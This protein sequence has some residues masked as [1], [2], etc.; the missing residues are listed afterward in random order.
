MKYIWTFFFILFMAATGYFIYRLGVWD[1]QIKPRLWNF[2]EL[3]R[4]LKSTLEDSIQQAA[5]EIYP[6]DT[7][8]QLIQSLNS[9]QKLQEN[10]MQQEMEKVNQMKTEIESLLNMEDTSQTANFKRLAK[11]YEAMQPAD[12]AQILLSMDEKMVVK[13]LV[14]MKPRNAG[15]VLGEVTRQ[16]PEKSA[17]LAEM[18]VKMKAGK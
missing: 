7:I 14:V 15:Q 6:M 17:R 12:V 5:R 3:D 1:K 18:I 10:I 13:V 4:Q 9:E 16:D 2:L 8:N 11:I